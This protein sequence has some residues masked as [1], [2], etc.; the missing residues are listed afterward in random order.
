[1]DTS[2][3]T[4]PS[5]SSRFYPVMRGL[6][7]L[8]S[9]SIDGHLRSGP[10]R[11]RAAPH[12]I[13]AHEHASGRRLDDGHRQFLLHA[14]GWPALWPVGLLGLPEL[15]DRRLTE[16]L[17]A[18]LAA[19][20]DLAAARLEPEEVYPVAWAREGGSAVVVGPGRHRAGHVIWFEGVSTTVYGTFTVF[21]DAAV[22]R[23]LAVAGPL[24]GGTPADSEP[25]R[26]PLET[27]GLGVRGDSDEALIPGTRDPPDGGALRDTES[28]HHFLLRGDPAGGRPQIPGRDGLQDCGGGSGLDVDG[29]RFGPVLRDEQTGAGGGYP[30]ERHSAEVRGAH[31]ALIAS[32]HRHARGLMRPIA[33]LPRRVDGHGR[34]VPQDGCDRHVAG[35]DD[36][37][38]RGN[39]LT[40][41]RFGGYFEV[42]HGHTL[43]V[44]NSAVRADALYLTET[45]HSLER[46]TSV[47]PTEDVPGITI[48]LSRSRET[49]TLSALSEAIGRLYD[50]DQQSEMASLQAL[51]DDIIAAG[52][53]HY[54]P[55]WNRD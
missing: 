39:D 11:P 53:P 10:P 55:G 6:V 19:T 2:V 32:G 21:F 40:G 49:E 3:P 41:H 36:T 15:G 45:F 43:P 22:A 17:L 46:P 27:G 54:D 8:A 12:A 9:L 44:C 48:R 7:A 29:V 14:N 47:S 30:R 4:P 1:M 35:K 20:G 13:A 52:E 38:C 51:R 5:W 23:L 18:D 33:L 34:A 50:Q 37:W 31:R 28:R 16:R 25:E 26:L 42:G 24:A